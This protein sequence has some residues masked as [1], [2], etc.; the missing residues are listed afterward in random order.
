DGRYS[1]QIEVDTYS[2]GIYLFNFTISGTNYQSSDITVAVTV[3]PHRTIVV[4]TYDGSISMG[5]NVTVNLELLDQDTG[6]SLIIGNLSSVLAEWT[7]GSAA[8]GSLQITIESQYW[9]IG[10][11]TID[12]TVYTTTSPR[13]FFDGTTAILVNVQ[14]MTAALSWDNIDVFPI[15]DDFEITTH[16]IVNESNSIYDGLPVNN[17]LQSHFRIRDKNGTLYTIKSFSAQ[18]SGTYVLTLDQS[19]FPG[20]SY[21]IRIFLVFGGAENYSSTQTPIISF[22]FDQA[23]CDLSSPDY[24]LLTISW[25]TDAIVTL[26]FVD[27][28]RGQGID[29]ATISVIGATKLG[30]Q[31][32]SSGR[33]RVTIDTSSWAIGS[34]QVNF[35]ASAPNYDDKTI[36]LSITIRQIRT[37]AT[38]T[39]SDLEIPVGDSRT[40]YVD[41]IDMDHDLPIFTLNHLCNWTAHYVIVWTGSRYSITINT[42][43]SDALTSYLLVFDYSSGAEYEAASFNV[44][45]VL[46]SIKTELRL[47]SPVEDSTP[48]GQI[49]ILVY[50]GDRDHL[51]GIASSDVLC[52]VWNT[53]NQL[54]ITWDNDSSAGAGYYIIT[55]SASQFGRLG[56][57]QLTV[58][59]NWT[60]S[61][62]KYEN[63]FLSIPVEIIGEETDLALIEAAI[64]SP[65]LDYMMYTFLYSSVS[66]ST[67]ITND[68]SDVFINV[69]FFG[70]SVDLSQVDIWEI[71]SILR[72]GEYS[73][74]FNNSIIGH[75]GIFSLKVFINWSAG[76][77]PYYTN[78]TDLISVRVLPRTASLSIIPP[79][80]VPFG[81]NATFSFTYEDT[82]GGVSNPIIYD[83]GAMT[84]SLNVPDFTLTYNALEELYIISFN[85]SQLGAPLGA[86]TLILNLTWSGLPFYSNVTGRS[87][88]IVLVERQ[89]ILTYPTPP[90]TAYG[91]NA[92]FTVTFVDIAGSDSKAVLDTTIEVYIGLI[93]I[94]S[95]HI[96]ITDLGFGDYQIDL[97]TSYFSQPGTYSIRIE[98]SSEQFY[99]Q[100]RSAT[101]NLAVDMRATVLT[102]EPVGAIPYGNSFSVVL[103]YQDLDTLSAI[104]N[105]TGIMTSLEILNGTDWLFTCLWRPS[106]QNYLLTV[107]T[108]N[109]ALEIGQTYH[110]WLNFSSEYTEP[111]YR[112]N[113]IFVSFS[114]R[115]RDTSLDLI[116]SPSQT[117]YQDLANFTIF[118]KDI[119]SSSGITGGSIYLFYGLELLE[120]SI[121]YTIAEVSAGQYEISV[122]TSYLGPP[123]LKAIQV[124]ANW[125]AG[126]PYYNEAQ[127]TI[128]IPVTERPA[129]VEIVFP[130]GQTWYLDNMTLDFAFVDISTGQRVVVSLSDIKIYSG[131]SL[132]AYGEYVVQPIGSIYRLQINSTVIDTNL[133]S[134]W[135]ITIQIDWTAGPPYYEND[136]TSIFVNTVGRVGNI[137]LI[138]IEETPFG[139]IMIINLTYTDQRSGQP[140][141]GATIILDCIEVP[142]LIEGTDYWVIVG[143]GIDSGKYGILVDTT[144]LGTLGVFTFEIEVQWSVLV[145]PYYETRIA[146]EVQGLVR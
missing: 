72:P 145:S 116:S 129:N 21:G 70:I 5:S 136:A 100:T 81:E 133:V 39:V 8:Y 38:A 77:S 88:G 32:I 108:S 130:P 96:Q 6:N 25:S 94:P 119:I 47:L 123:G 139:D 50:Y 63:R 51:Q 126:S 18:G 140:I 55:I 29:T 31:L 127:R 90:L 101:K 11:Y 98:A 22:Q 111:F 82:T 52:T 34:Y 61:I 97:N 49:E 45:V 109:Q 42:Y 27:I 76:V 89:T 79:T 138:P 135:N 102:S 95:T 131:G 75:T 20:G 13:Y 26:E 106:L 67:K 134:D 3:R 105:A 56:I 44:T 40:F 113:D 14:K 125:S 107:E 66:T 57:Q 43:D 117:Q 73:I 10:T 16:V 84:I 143:T 104:G 58:F 121:N 110:L 62:L 24:P 69:E 12:I 85:T 37:Y 99:Y 144:S 122:D 71:D 2:V 86:R 74:G 146:P 33:Y 35:T 118:F 19:Y 64:P 103:Y 137:E 78:R 65:C 15:G 30:Q 83:S 142:G 23:Q 59:F 60:G 114:M 1:I 141:E 53:T 7:G 46:R 48:S 115:E 120:P 128:N 80:N 17:L 41:Y 124:I 68:T 132:L 54:L 9:A 28:D 93:M 91:N 36:S 112:W 87:V 4:A 92:T